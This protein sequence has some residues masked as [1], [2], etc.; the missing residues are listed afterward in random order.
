MG[1]GETLRRYGAFYL[2]TSLAW[3]STRAIG[4]VVLILALGRA[5]LKEL[6]RFKAR[7][8]FTVEG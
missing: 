8:E 1:L 6:R 7:F 2:V 4:N 3:D 5:V